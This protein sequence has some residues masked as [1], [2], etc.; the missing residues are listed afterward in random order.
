MRV[1]HNL[2]DIP[3]ENGSLPRLGVTIGNFDGVH[4]GHRQLL[5]RIKRECQELNLRFV[6]V[7]FVPHPHKILHPEKD[8][9]LLS[10]Y[11]QRRK[12][13]AE[14]GVDF[15]V[16]LPFTRD[17]STLT[18]EAFLQDY[19]FS[20]P[21]LAKF[22]LGYDFAFGTNKHGG[23]DAVRA[24]CAPRGIEV[25]IQPKFEYENRVISSSLVREMLGRG[26]LENVGKVLQRPFQLQGVVIKGEGRG[27]KI[28]FPTANIQF[29]PDLM[30]PQKG[31]YVSR[32]LYKGMVYKS[33]TNIGNNP[34][35]KDTNQ[36]HVETNLFDFNLD[37]YGEQLEIQFLKKIRDEFKFQTVN[38]LITQIRHDVEAARLFLETA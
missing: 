21:E 3:A 37:I 6:A 23:H 5:S 12:L 31:V 9:F 29:H 35:F 36:L 25:E 11:D 24:L 7:T 17:F 18:A 13:L 32:T 14:Q 27:R 26:E 22:F 19:L 1:L 10:S 8:G 38:D 2:R 34:T 16:E 15:L 28:G 30:V 20:Y 33:V 4:V